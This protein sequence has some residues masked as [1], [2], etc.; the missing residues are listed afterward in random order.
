[1]PLK[2]DPP[3]DTKNTSTGEVA[4]FRGTDV[5]ISDFIDWVFTKGKTAGEFIE[6][7]PQLTRQHIR[8]Y[9]FFSLPDRFLPYG[10]DR[11]WA[12]EHARTL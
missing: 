6:L 2:L 4:V 12:P 8:D 7:N 10:E 5:K 11:D 1:M 3:Y 9:L